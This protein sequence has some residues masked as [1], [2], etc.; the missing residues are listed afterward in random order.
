[1]READSNHGTIQLTLL[2]AVSVYSEKQN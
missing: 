1:M 2:A